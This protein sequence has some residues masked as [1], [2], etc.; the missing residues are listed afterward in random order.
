MARTKP[1]VKIAKVIWV[2]ITTQSGHFCTADAQEQT[3]TLF[4]TVGT[5]I[6]DTKHYLHLS[7]MVHPTGCADPFIIPKGCI[8]HRKDEKWVLPMPLTLEET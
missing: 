6:K 3:P 8:L 4:A 7:S 1:W 5:I 2:D